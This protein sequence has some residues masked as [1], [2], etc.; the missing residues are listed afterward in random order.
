[1]T[2][3]VLSHNHAGYSDWY[4]PSID[5]LAL[6]YTNLSVPGIRVFSGYDPS[7]YPD[8]IYVSS[9]EGYIPADDWK[10]LNMTPGSQFSGSIYPA[11]SKMQYNAIAA[12]PIRTF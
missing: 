9:S 11:Q 5:E 6:I 10:M 4:I 12:V 7:L 8:A 3:L 2:T 1:M